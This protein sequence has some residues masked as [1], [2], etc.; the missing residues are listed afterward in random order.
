[1][2]AQLVLVSSS[3]LLVGAYLASLCQIYCTQ[4]HYRTLSDDIQVR[5]AKR[6]RNRETF[7]EQMLQKGK[8]E[9]K[10]AQIAA[11]AA[12]DRAHPAVSLRQHAQVDHPQVGQAS[13]QQ[14]THQPL[15]SR[16]MT[17]VQMKTSTFLVGE[18]RLN[19]EPFAIPPAGCSGPGILD[20]HLSGYMLSRRGC[21]NDSRFK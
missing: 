3:R 4:I 19:C 16:Q 12:M 9:L 13:G 8:S 14:Q 10:E 11:S 21:G 5:W 15:W 17:T 1:M 18:E 2:Y 6:N 20:N 7:V